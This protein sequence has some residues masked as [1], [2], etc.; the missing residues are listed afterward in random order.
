LATL[1]CIFACCGTDDADAV[2][3]L[4][5]EAGVGMSSRLPD[6]RRVRAFHDIF[7]VVRSGHVAKFLIL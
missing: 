2:E 3:V 7:R 5:A 1:C 4:S 6:L